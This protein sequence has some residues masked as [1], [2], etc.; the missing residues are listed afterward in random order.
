MQDAD[1]IR[2]ILTQTGRLSAQHA[3]QAAA[4]AAKED[5]SFSDALIALTLLN[6]RDVRALQAELAGLAFRDALPELVPQSTVDMISSQCAHRWNT[7]PIEYA[8]AKRRLTL[9]INNPEHAP[10]IEKLFSFMMQPFALH[11][12]V[13]PDDVIG[14]A[15]AERLPND[16]PVPET[17]PEDPTQLRSLNIKPSS[18]PTHLDASGKPPS[19]D[20]R[21]NRPRRTKDYVAYETMSRALISAVALS[22]RMHLAD[23]VERLS[24][25]L[26]R[27]R[28][29]Q[30]VGARLKLSPTQRDGLV[31]SAWA[32][33][34][35][36]QR[37]LVQQLVTPYNV[38]E[39]VFADEDSAGR[40]RIEGSVLSLVNAYQEL[41]RLHPE[42]CHDVN[43]ARRELKLRWAAPGEH[44][45]VVE[46]FLQVL[47]D[48]EFL[49]SLDE[50]ARRI[51]IVDPDEASFGPVSQA[52]SQSGYEVAAIGD[53]AEAER[54]FKDF[55]PNV[56]LVSMDLP[57]DGG[58]SFCRRIRRMDD[59]NALTLM[60]LISPS[61]N[62]MAAACLRE[63]ADDFLSK[64]VDAELLFLKLR[65]RLGNSGDSDETTESNR[66]TG[67]SGQLSEMSFNDM[68]QIFSSGR[69]SIEIALEDE[70]KQGRVWMKDG[71]IVHATS[72]NLTGEAAFHE[73]MRWGNGEFNTIQVSVFPEASIET[74]TMSLLMEG[75]RL[76]DEG[77][78]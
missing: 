61:D 49:S 73:L 48:E 14:A 34:L 16:P 63:G 53:Q 10:S 5:I 40:R 68:I 64:P 67:V 30:L 3:E 71:Q 6:A 21:G 52:L 76:A 20:R 51:L 42:V 8:E 18:K 23:D 46:T 32:S 74:S 35:W 55:Q 38:E 39:V 60:A 56:V 12:V 70:Q 69:R 15:I 66:Q 50:N 47:V 7:F 1:Q 19:G 24:G 11:F 78:D 25:I 22:A 75:S 29:C 26:E 37:D 65:A 54:I 43:V 72:G 45:S 44:Q 77:S 59:S 36:P 58:L 13:V 17:E 2:D 9:A 41:H 31:V 27:V 28:Y 57:H 33:A 62:R 4:H